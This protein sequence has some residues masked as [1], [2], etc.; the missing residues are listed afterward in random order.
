MEYIYLLQEREFIKTNEIIYKIGKT[1]QDNLKRL[2]NYPKGSSLIIQIKCNDCNKYERIIL[3]RF[4]EKF[5]QKKEIG[6]EYFMGDCNDMIDLIYSIIRIDNNDNNNDNDNDNNIEE[7]KS[8][9]PPLTKSEHIKNINSKLIINNYTYDFNTN[10]NNNY[11]INDKFINNFNF[12]RIDYITINEM[13]KIILNDD[14]NIIQ[15]YINYKYFNYNFPENFNIKCTNY[16]KC[17]IKNNDNWKEIDIKYL[18]DILFQKNSLEI[19]NYYYNN[20][21]EIDNIVKLDLNDKINNLNHLNKTV[22]KNIK[23]DIK[24]MIKTTTFNNFHI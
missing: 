18:I 5:I 9:F 23:N 8:Y 16:N 15:K 10:L 6:N 22:I 20:K 2:N 17:L 11:I 13:I 4:K 1:K 21:Y 3:N 24:E 12:E 14:N 7:Y 19:Y